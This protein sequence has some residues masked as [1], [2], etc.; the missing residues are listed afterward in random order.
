MITTTKVWPISNKCLYKDQERQV[1]DK[2]FFP[3]HKICQ[4]VRLK[5]C[6]SKALIS[7]ASFPLLL[8]LPF[9]KKV[10]N[11]FY[12]TDLSILP[13]I[14]YLFHQIPSILVIPI[15]LYQRCYYSSILFI[16]AFRL[17]NNHLPIFFIDNLLFIFNHTKYRL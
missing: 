4:K 5:R 8:N 7:T 11:A 3:F 13:V 6:L 2:H 1:K 16:T 10:I 14:P 17:Q 9:F 15:P 12:Q